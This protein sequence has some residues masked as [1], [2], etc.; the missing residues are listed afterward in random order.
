[1]DEPNSRIDFQF[2]EGETE[3]WLDDIEVVEVDAIK[4]NP[5][6]YI[7]FEY[8]ATRND[9]TI[10]LNDDYIDVKGIPVSST[11]TLKPFSSII[12]FKNINHV[13]GT[14]FKKKDS[15]SNVKVYP[16]P[17]NE[18]FNLETDEN[19][20][21]V[22]RLYNSSGQLIKLFDLDK[23]LNSINVSN[24]KAGL[25]FIQIPTKQ[26]NLIKKMTKY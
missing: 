22:C 2:S 16:N 12:L 25:Y 17:V 19:S 1:L 3:I 7:R 23:G 5:D 8:N 20:I 21:S 13:T 26:G 14:V 24:L 15:E 18:V 4:N 11:I 10:S 9:K 6:D